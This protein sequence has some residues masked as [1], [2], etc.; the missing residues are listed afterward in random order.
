MRTIVFALAI[1][2]SVCSATRDVMA[3]QPKE[4]CQGDFDS[5]GRVDF[6]DFVMFAG[7]FGMECLEVSPD[8]EALVAVYNA[9]DGSNWR[10][11]RQVNWLS[12]RPLGEWSGVTINDS[13]RVVE[14]NLS[15][16]KITDISALD[17]LTAL[18]R[19][20]LQ[21][22]TITDI[23]ALAGLVNLTYLN[24][25]HN[26]IADISALESLTKLT[27][28]GLW[29]NAIT[30]LSALAGMAR[31]KGL[32]LAQNTIADI[33][34]LDSLTNL[35]VLELQDNVVTDISALGNLTKLE[36]LN[37]QNNNITDISALAG[38]TELETLALRGNPLNHTALSD[39]I[40]ALMGRGVEVHID[41]NDRALLF[42]LYNANR[43]DNGTYETHWLSN[44]PLEQWSGVTTDFRNVS[45]EM[46]QLSLEFSE[47]TDGIRW[48]S[49]VG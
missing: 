7:V 8:R 16:R 5:N 45:I 6:A 32:Y 37:L 38:L 12:S 27:V 48:Y 18:A 10:T 33:G 26:T 9:S 19:L 25:A 29:N 35:T 39:H 1:V 46:R 22:N 17:S 13:G 49:Q 2:A 43:W 30:D 23:S 3:I 15:S 31:L 36:T 20:E 34:A 40:P 4:I 41:A 21:S 28:L 14:L 42:A 11:G 24:L 44:Q 47:A